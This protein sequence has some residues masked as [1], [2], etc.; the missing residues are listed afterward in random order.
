[1]SASD[2]L[3]S[4]IDY[5][6]LIAS[7]VRLVMSAWQAFGAQKQSRQMSC[8]RANAASLLISILAALRGSSSCSAS[9]SS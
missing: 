8:F 3:A 1:M 9:Q 5:S 7:I 2:S 4:L 6:Q